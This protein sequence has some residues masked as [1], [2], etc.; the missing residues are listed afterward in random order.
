VFFFA[1]VVWLHVCFAVWAGP[2]KKHGREENGVEK[3][4][5]AITQAKSGGIGSF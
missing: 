1:V 2:K 5:C 4:S 3:T